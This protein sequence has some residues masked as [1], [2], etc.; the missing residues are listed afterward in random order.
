MGTMH[1]RNKHTHTHTHTH[2]RL[3]ALFPG[4]PRWAST[5]KSIWILLK[6]E[7]MSSI[8]I[9]WA[10]CISLQTDNYAS[11]PLSFL[12]AGCPS[13]C[14]TNSVKALKALEK[15]WLNFG[16]DSG[17]FPNNSEWCRTGPLC[18]SVAVMVVCIGVLLWHVCTCCFLVMMLWYHAIL[19][20]PNFVALS[21]L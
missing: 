16:S 1:W 4:L 13:C 5:R 19:S 6:Q 3:T 2:T 11:T 21:S 20:C 14:P 9:S 10:V 12:Q 15:I 18:T 17:S 7:T 8:G